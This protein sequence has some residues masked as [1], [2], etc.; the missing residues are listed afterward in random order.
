MDIRAEMAIDS[1]KNAAILGAGAAVYQ[2]ATDYA[3]EMT[4]LAPWQAGLIQG[5]GG[6][7][8]CAGLGAAD[9]KGSQLLAMVFG[10]GGMVAGVRKGVVSVR[11]SMANAQLAAN[12]TATTPTAGGSTN[13]AA[14]T[15]ALGA[16]PTPPAAAVMGYSYARPA[17]YSR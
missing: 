1:L 3:F 11:Q 8:V 15:P 12:P 2:N 13:A 10:V 7:A 16:G 6:L 17:A 9:F 5:L 4:A 14:T